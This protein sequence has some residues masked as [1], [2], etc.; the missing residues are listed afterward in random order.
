MRNTLLSIGLAALVSFHSPVKADMMF[1]GAGAGTCSSFISPPPSFDRNT[2]NT[3]VFTWVQG[4]IS[5]MNGL[6]INLPGVTPLF[7]LEMVSL[8]AQWG[9]LLAYCKANP[10]AQIAAAAIDLAVTRL[11]KR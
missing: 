9:Y 10:N 2:V 7:D 11:K 3:S 6:A 4:F 8:D 1:A 5:G